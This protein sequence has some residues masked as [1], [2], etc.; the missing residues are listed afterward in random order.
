MVGAEFCIKCH[1]YLKGDKR[2]AQAAPYTGR[3][4]QAT[5]AMSPTNPNANRV[6]SGNVTKEVIAARRLVGPGQSGQTVPNT[7][8]E[9]QLDGRGIVIAV[10]IGFILML[11]LFIAVLPR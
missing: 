8:P 3:A 9:P 6:A 11:I 10:V 4:A 2:P 7:P 1:Y 5:N